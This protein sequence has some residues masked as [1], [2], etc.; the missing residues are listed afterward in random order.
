VPSPESSTMHA[1]AGHS[2]PSG[3]TPMTE[4]HASP[5]SRRRRTCVTTWDG[6]RHAK[7]WPSTGSQLGFSGI[8]SSTGIWFHD[9]RQ[10]EDVQPP[11]ATRG[12]SATEDGE[13][14]PAANQALSVRAP[15]S[16]PGSNGGKLDAFGGRSIAEA[17][18]PELTSRRPLPCF[19]HARLVGD[20]GTEIVIA[21]SLHSCGSEPSRGARRINPEPTVRNFFSAPCSSLSDISGCSRHRT[22]PFAEPSLMAEIFGH[23]VMFDATTRTDQS[24]ANRQ[25]LPLESAPD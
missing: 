8:W 4:H 11:A 5:S 17:R 7:T 19:P 18:T 13:E 14:H 3:F 16:R 25:L 1:I 10:L 22:H 12:R 6:V 24:Q 21:D 2:S 15:G 20:G 9:R 23:L